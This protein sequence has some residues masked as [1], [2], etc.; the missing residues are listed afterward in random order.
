MT[1]LAFPKRINLRHSDYSEENVG[2]RLTAL[3]ARDSVLEQE[4]Q[5]E[6]TIKRLRVW[7]RNS[8]Y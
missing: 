6:R 1:V 8:Q 3:M 4:L 7:I 5:L 2:H